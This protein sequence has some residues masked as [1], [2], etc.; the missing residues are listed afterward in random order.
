MRLRSLQPALKPVLSPHRA[1]VGPV[2]RPDQDDTVWAS[3]G[4]YRASPRS[5][6]D[7]IPSFFT[8]VSA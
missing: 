8:T 1:V 6:R 3:R 7:G 4:A 5:M 2:L